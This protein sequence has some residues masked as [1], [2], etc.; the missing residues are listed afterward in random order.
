MP[1]VAAPPENGKSG[2][3]IRRAENHALALT[4]FFNEAFR[5]D[6]QTYANGKYQNAPG[7][8]LENTRE[9]TQRF[10]VP[11]ARISTVFTETLSRVVFARRT[12]R[13]RCCHFVCRRGM[14]R[15]RDRRTP[16]SHKNYR[17]ADC[18]SSRKRGRRPCP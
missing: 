13:L 9:P 17:A 11:A 15:R 1:I 12:K 8:S 6:A 10:G 2:T 18:R 7:V 16:H 4:F 5:F 14:G 3:P